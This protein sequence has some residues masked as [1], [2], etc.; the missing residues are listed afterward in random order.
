M[1]PK[2]V[3]ALPLLHRPHDAAAAAVAALR[4]LIGCPALRGREREGI[5]DEM[6]CL[7]ALGRLHRHR[8]I[9]SSGV[10]AAA[11]ERRY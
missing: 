5:D 2:T 6:G 8:Q 4:T 1:L 11:N 9:D 7:M 10:A 3:H